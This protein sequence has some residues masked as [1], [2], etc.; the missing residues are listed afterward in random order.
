MHPSHIPLEGKAQA[1]LLRC[2]CDAGPCGGFLGDHD[3]S[4][5]M[6]CKD[7]VQMAEEFDG[8]QIFIFSVLVGD[9]VPVAAPVVQI[10]H[11]GHG[12]HRSGSFSP[13]FS[14]NQRPLFPSR[15]ARLFW[16][17]R[18]HKAVPRQNPPGHGRLLENGPGPSL[19]SRRSPFCGDN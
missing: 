14:R 5:H 4:G 18:T 19:R 2:L 11:G 17:L 16:D 6:A 7:A 13:R 3:G 8:L 15:D 12:V 1:A 10:Q 9:P